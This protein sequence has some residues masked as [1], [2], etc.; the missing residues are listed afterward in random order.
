MGFYWTGTGFEE[1]DVLLPSPPS[2]STTP[3][4]Q[5]PATIA[6]TP[7]QA[8]S[9][10]AA[11][12]KLLSTQDEVQRKM[13][14]GTEN[15]SMP[16]SGTKDAESGKKKEG[17]SLERYDPALGLWVRAEE[18]VALSFPEAEAPTESNPAAP[19]AAN[20][21]DPPAQKTAR[22]N[23]SLFKWTSW[24]R[25]EPGA[26]EGRLLATPPAEKSTEIET[27]PDP[28]PQAVSDTSASIAAHDSLSSGAQTAS[29]GE[30]ASLPAP[31]LTST[32]DATTPEVQIAAD[33]DAAVLAA[34]TAPSQSAAAPDAQI[35]SEEIVPVPAA[36]QAAAQYEAAPDEQIAADESTSEPPPP[37]TTAQD[38]AAAEAQ[39][40]TLEQDIAVTVPSS[41]P[42]N[43]PG[44][45]MWESVMNEEEAISKAAS[46]I[47]ETLQETRDKD[48]S[49]WFVLKGMLGGASA[50][51]SSVHEPAGSIPVLEVF[52]LAG[53]V[54]K[55]SLVATLG[56]ALSSRGERVLMVEATPI[57]SLQYFFG[58]CDCRPGVLRTFRPPSSSSDAPIRLAT[59]EPES[60][61]SDSAAQGTL[62]ADIQRWAQGANRVIVD[63]STGSIGT[64]R[65]LSKLSPTV[66]VPLTPDVNSVVTANSIDLFLKRHAGA[67]ANQADIFYVL[68]Q[69][70]SSLPLHVDVRRVLRERLGDRLLPF[71]LERTPAVSEA[72][73]EGMTVM[74]YA[75]ESKAAADF[76]CLAEWLEHALAPAAVSPHGRWSEG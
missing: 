76:A 17:R 55:T 41:A 53:G 57:A 12:R 21:A 14:P 39:I 67:S 10:E 49:R 30:N 72:L 18:E 33:E 31:S 38:T 5:Q 28:V 27:Q 22:E 59:A 7:E 50:Q 45:I 40:E 32:Q 36:P 26:G 24:F 29:A 74:D 3:E 34:P 73:A 56:R 54:G 71:A 15:R 25:I 4:S 62:A 60:L 48:A 11:V 46:S 13:A 66:L 58:A 1:S 63:V 8:S 51:E 9:G 6:D 23:G 2:N 16:Q 64:I 52:S 19:P 42:D 70:D 47:G 37:Q 35:A 69:F 65:T 20:T 44:D 43:K 75:P 61:M 68:S